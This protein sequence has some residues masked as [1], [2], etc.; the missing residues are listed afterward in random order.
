ML[1]AR[2]CQGCRRGALI[3]PDR[4]ATT[5]RLTN[6]FVVLPYLRI[7]LC[8]LRFRR[9][10]LSFAWPF[11]RLWGG[12]VT[13]G[14][15]FLLLLEAARGARLGPFLA[16]LTHLLLSQVGLEFPVHHPPPNPA[17]AVRA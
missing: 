17:S 1:P 10:S 12:S 4:S 7:L 13:N 9:D 11:R 3:A 5:Q 6:L 16:F 2:S 8:W 15:A 14:P